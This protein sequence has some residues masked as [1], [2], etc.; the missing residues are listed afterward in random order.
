MHMHPQCR[1]S[2]THFLCFIFRAYQTL[3]EFYLSLPLKYNKFSTTNFFPMCVRVVQY[4]SIIY[5]WQYRLTVAVREKFSARSKTRGSSHTIGKKILR[6]RGARGSVPPNPPPPP[7]PTSGADL[8][9]MKGGG[10]Q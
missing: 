4:L 2:S 8:E 1:L 5:L 9:I 6:D 7:P 10:H 3:P